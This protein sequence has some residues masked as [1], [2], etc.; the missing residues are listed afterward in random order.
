MYAVIL[1]LVMFLLARRIDHPAGPDTGENQEG[2]SRG[3]GKPDL[4]CFLQLKT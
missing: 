4:D 1:I 2:I 3:K